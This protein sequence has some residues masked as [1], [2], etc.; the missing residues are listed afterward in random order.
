M[1]DTGASALMLFRS[2]L[3]KPTSLSTGKLATATNVG[4]GFQRQAVL[5]PDMHLGKENLGPQKGFVVENQRDDG[6][7]FDGVWT[8][9]SLL[10]RNRLR[11]KTTTSV[12]RNKPGKPK[13]LLP[14]SEPAHLSRFSKEP[15]LSRAEGWASRFVVHSSE[16]ATRGSSSSGVIYGFH[17]TPTASSFTLTTS[18][19]QIKLCRRSAVAD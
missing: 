12:G 5:I 18:P 7:D 19:N 14:L 3:N 8:Y 9:G 16:S 15:A 17:S 6:R 11:F 13:C 10:G 2:R 1:V 4:G